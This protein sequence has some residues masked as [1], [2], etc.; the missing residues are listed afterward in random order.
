MSGNKTEVLQ[1]CG[2]IWMKTVEHVGK[3]SVSERVPLVLKDA[4]G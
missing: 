3:L 1:P 4:G 2:G